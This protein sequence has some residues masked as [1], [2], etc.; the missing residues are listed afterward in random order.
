MA[1]EKP[2]MVVQYSIAINTVLQLLFEEDS[3]YAIDLEE[4]EEGENMT[5]F[6]HA[7]ANVTPFDFYRQVTGNDTDIL[8]FNHIANRLV[9]QYSDKP[10]EQESS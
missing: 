7:L 6:L 2:D 8:G 4:F 5:H 9:Y 3:D 1:Y 10:K